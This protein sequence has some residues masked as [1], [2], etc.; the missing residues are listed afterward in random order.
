MAKQG[1]AREVRTRLYMEGRLVENAFVSITTSSGV[2]QPAMAQIELVP[3]NTIKHIMPFT[4][5]HVFTTD[6]WDPNPTGGL[7]DF[8]LLFEGVVVSRGF[9][10]AEAARSFMVQCADASIFWTKAKQFW[11]NFAEANGGLVDQLAVQT[12]GGYGRFGKVGTEGTYGYMASKLAFAD[13]DKPEERFMDTLIS[14][15][16][17]IGNVNP[18]YT[19]A[20]NRFRITDRIL[21]GPAGK[22]EKLFQLSLISDFLDGLA[23]RVSGQ[24]DLVEVVNQLLGAI[25]H[26]WTSVSAPPYIKAR[27][28]DRD[29]FGNVK[30]IK[31]TV[32]DRGPRGRESVELFDVQT[33]VDDI[34][35]SFI[36]KPHLYTVAPPNC[37]VLFPNM[38]EHQNHT[39]SF[40]EDPTRLSMKPTLPLVGASATMGLLFQRPT[41]LEV[42]TAMIRDPQRNASAKRSPD[43]TYG[44]AAGQT[45]TFSDFDWTTNEERIR[46][47]VYNFMNL[48]PA[49]A[50]LT[51]SD[52]GK[53]TPTGARQGGLPKYLQNVA[54][55]EW[56]K[57]KYA[58]RQTELNGPYNM[59]PI[60][61][62][63]LVALDDS[64]ANL[65]LVANLIGITHMVRASGQATTH[66][67]IQ[68]AR[69]MDEVDY[70]R[71]RF[72]GGFKDPDKTELNVDLIR[73]E[74]GQYDFKRLFDGTNHPPIPEWF[75]ATFRNVL[76]LDVK[77]REWFGP[78][79]GVM[80]RILFRNPG[81]KP[82]SDVQ[83]KLTEFGL[84]GL[85][86]FVEERQA[87]EDILEKNE[88][89]TIEEAA[90]ALNIRY[91]A[92]RDNGREFE[93]VSRLT[94]RGFTKID[95]A[96]RFVGASP[97][98]F[99]DRSNQQGPL[100][101][102]KNP[103]SSRK[104]DYRTASFNVFVGDTSNGSGYSGAP[105]G[106]QQ[107]NPTTTTTENVGGLEADAV[108]GADPAPAA[109]RMSG[110]FPVFD[111]RIHSG[112]EA[113]DAR[114]RAAI[115][116]NERDPSGYARYDGR[117]L[118]YDFEARLWQESLQA[119]GYAPGQT[120]DA[121]SA[122]HIV[123]N[124]NVVRPKTPEE[125][126]ADAQTRREAIAARD[127]ANA[128]TKARG[129]SVPT[130]KS[131]TTMSPADQAP[132]GDG[133]EENRRD[134]LP[135]PLSEKQVV[136]M[137]RAIIDAY[138]AELARTRGFQG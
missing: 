93:E 78:G 57:S 133:L 60:P 73:D 110:A 100:T 91:R 28:F 30:R 103:A 87:Y 77:Y 82:S 131:R 19:N 88:N 32:K 22:T 25:F 61:G 36:F 12:S 74:N 64:P 119:A 83:V 33:A 137:R 20:R 23:N 128:K 9:T 112:K 86:D 8:K 51:L 120:P 106:S 55:Y 35:G 2:G 96:F 107:A 7:E 113:T 132:T 17:D 95:E 41:E 118:M 18:F 21:R 111:T 123:E 116:A 56:Y 125:L 102:A 49:P 135:Q 58:S 71:P 98:E 15:L 89:I 79:A 105:E 62:F 68:Y 50:A 38:Y 138:R 129:K 92:A 44:D 84:G 76:D 40:L 11:M 24:S 115:A 130:D 122:D 34:V 48:A 3:T 59:R 127:Q 4:W 29:I 27:I 80:Q 67:Q 47:L 16:D 109:N 53:R 134:P 31:T 75:D 1:T 85:L 45:P 72:I 46:G 54:S 69:L 39:E 108:S 124:G 10:R 101:F 14:V 136:D 43:G 13:K 97:V 104:I 81:D 52:P 121:A 117:P 63:P 126:A 65:N 37:N 6:P 94:Q 26:E 42:F 70:N 66:Y 5:V 99:A 114:A 90:T